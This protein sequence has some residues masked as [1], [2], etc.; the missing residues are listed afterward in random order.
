MKNQILKTS[1]DSNIMRLRLRTGIR[2]RTVRN[3]SV[4]ISTPPNFS[5]YHW[6]LYF[7]L[8]NAIPWGSLFLCCQ[9]QRICPESNSV[10]DDRK[11]CTTPSYG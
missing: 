4:Y 9:R 5:L 8:Q 2:Q 3:S 11:R 7:E 1:A 10:P 6:L